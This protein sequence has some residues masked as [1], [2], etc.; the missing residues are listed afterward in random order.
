MPTNKSRR[1]SIYR[2]NNKRR[3]SSRQFGGHGVGIIMQLANQISNENMKDIKPILK[4]IQDEIRDGTKETIALEKIM[5]KGGYIGGTIKEIVNDSITDIKEDIMDIQKEIVKDVKII[6]SKAVSIATKIIDNNSSRDIS[7]ICNTAIQDIHRTMTEELS[8]LKDAYMK[9]QNAKSVP[10]DQLNNIK[11]MIDNK[12]ES[13]RKF[14]NDYINKINEL[15]KTETGK[16]EALEF[17]SKASIEASY[18]RTIVNNVIQSI[19]TVL[20]AVTIIATAATPF[21]YLMLPLYAVLLTMSIGSIYG[22]KESSKVALL[23]NYTNTVAS[24][25]AYIAEYDDDE[26]EDDD[27]YEDHT[28]QM[29]MISKK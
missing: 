4:D 26:N 7:M 6:S 20:G 23:S 22:A 29:S 17:L 1:K 25:H 12:S 8:S 28:K 18:G 11:T 3:Q 13:I 5:K 16:R 14:N 24:T 2:L 10:I 19:T 21:G 15:I 9:L 27:E